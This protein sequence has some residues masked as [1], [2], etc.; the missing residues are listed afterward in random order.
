[1]KLVIVLLLSLVLVS[2]IHQK[3]E[4]AR[5]LKHKV[6]G[7]KQVKAHHV[8]HEHIQRIHHRVNHHKT[9]E[10]R[11]DPPAD[12]PADAPPADA[13]AAPTLE[14]FDAIWTF[15]TEKEPTRKT[16]A[17]S[18]AGEVVDPKEGPI[19]L[20][21]TEV[22][23]NNKV[24][25]SMNPEGQAAAPPAEGGAEAPA[26]E[27][28]AEQFRQLTRTGEPGSFDIEVQAKSY[29]VET[30]CTDICDISLTYPSCMLLAEAFCLAMPH[31]N[32]LSTTAAEGPGIAGDYRLW[33]RMQFHIECEEGKVKTVSETDR[34]SHT[35]MEGP[36]Q[37][38]D[39]RF[40]RVVTQVDSDQ[41]GLLGYQFY[42]RPPLAVE[43]SFQLLKFRTCPFIWHAPLL[44]IESCDA[45]GWSGYVKLGGS[46]FPTRKMWV[47]SAE[48]LVIDQGPIGNLWR[49]GSGDISMV[50]GTM[51]SEYPL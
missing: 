35:G 38:P 40:Q 44:V 2:A 28:G 25:L 48:K 20:D 36:L 39:G 3:N 29:I 23:D 41:R 21:P 34:S 10:A 11:E 37:A 16:E 7:T 19:T 12:A 26:P 24:E 30:T 32:V 6:H 49:C 45:G 15:F 5:K 33:S 9:R 22:D 17:E 50:R 31:L 43:P 1:M 47:D 51:P 13:E 18:K 27:G 42:G 46:G 14:N 8:Q 4:V